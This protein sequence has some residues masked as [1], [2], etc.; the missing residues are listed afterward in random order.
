[1]GVARLLHASANALQRRIRGAGWH[2]RPSGDLDSI[3]GRDCTLETVRSRSAHARVQVTALAGAQVPLFDPQLSPRLHNKH[4]PVSSKT[5]KACSQ[6][7][8]LPVASW[9]H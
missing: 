7:L 3:L 4:R 9:P 2:V 8:W 5:E 1:M 6:L